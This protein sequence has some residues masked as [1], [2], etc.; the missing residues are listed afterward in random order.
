MPFKSILLVTFDF[1]NLTVIVTFML[2]SFLK[3]FQGCLFFV[4][5]QSIFLLQAACMS[6]FSLVIFD[7]LNIH[8]SNALFK[9]KLLHQHDLTFMQT[10]EISLSLPL[11]LSSLFSP[12]TKPKSTS[13][14]LLFIQP[15]YSYLSSV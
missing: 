14:K 8:H 11:P 3:F 10:F 2:M 9:Y 6:Q 4:A 7:T 15:G 1:C 13:P 5:I 12:H